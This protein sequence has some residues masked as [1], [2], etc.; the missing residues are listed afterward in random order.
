VSDADVLVLGSGIAGLMLALGAA[1]HG[2]V[3]VLTKR[4]AEDANTNWAQGGIAAVFDRADS[5]RDHERD[6]LR[7]GAGLC[8]RDVVREVVRQAP[9]RVMALGSLG[10][11]FTRASRGLALGREGGH[12]HRRIVHAGD[13]TGHSIERAL[14]ER[15][16][17]HPRIRMLED[18]LAVDL[19]LDSRL[20]GRQAVRGR[21]TC[22]GAYVLDR[23]TGRIR[24]VTA[25]VTVLA[26]GGCGKVYLYTSNPDIATGDGLAMAYRAGVAVGNLEFMQFHP[27][28]LYHPRAKSFLI[29][30][31]LRGE[32][33]VLRTADGTRFMTRTH[34]D[35]ELAPRD[36]VARAIDRELKRR[37]EPHVWLDISHR[38]AGFLRKRFPN[39]DAALRGFGFDFTSEP[40]PVVPAAHYMCG[41]VLAA[42]SGRTALP[43]LLALGEVAC[44][45]LHGANRLA[46]NSLLEALVG[47]HLAV[48]EVRRRLKAVPRAPRGEAWRAHGTRPPQESVVFDHNWESVRRVMWDLVGIVRT[49][50]RLAFAARRLVLLGEEIEHDYV[51]QKLHP[52]LIELRNIALVGSLIVRCAQRRKESR[53]LHYNL[54]HPRRVAAAARPTV[55]RRIE[56]GRGGRGGVAAGAPASL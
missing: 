24:P 37:G 27:T 45:G 50:Q 28:C 35:A 36:V 13:F 22:W 43:G 14:I 39:I 4:R 52:D 9:E 56:R 8:D 30:E 10:V 15:V 11:R 47:A 48:E 34:R 26:T 32:G 1:E 23:P 12:S 41:G 54:D 17:E 29:S 51:R 31:A 16:R 6:T 25:R 38:P 18:Q 20:R 33:A 2:Q 40:I 5:F 3:L 53:G 21:D 55:V 7:C 42:L 46:S 19:I 49:D 44:T